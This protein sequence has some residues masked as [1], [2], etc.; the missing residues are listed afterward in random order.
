[1]IPAIAPPD[2]FD[3]FAGEEE[4]EGFV[5][6]LLN[7]ASSPVPLNPLS[8]LVTVAPPVPLYSRYSIRT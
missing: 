4:E 3:E 5:V 1:M 2:R 8:G 7:R 6:R